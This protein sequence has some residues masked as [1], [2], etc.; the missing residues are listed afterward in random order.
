MPSRVRAL[1]AL[2]LAAR[3]GGEPSRERTC[4]MANAGEEAI[5]DCGGGLITS[6]EF[7]SFGDPAGSCNAAG[8]AAGFEMRPTCHAVGTTDALEDR[9]LGQSTCMFNVEPAMFSVAAGWKCNPPPAGGRLRLAAVLTCR[10]PGAVDPQ[11]LADLKAQAAAAH[12]SYGWRIVG[13]ILGAF[14]LYFGCGVAFKVHREG[15]RG[16]EAVP[17]LEMWRDLPFL[18]W[19]GVI[20]TVDTLKSKGRPGYDSG[21]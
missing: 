14:C 9:C 21:L 8:G 4:A 15:A 19:D 11:V 12:A 16:V 1:A 20:F 5:F 6:V 18:V 17:H 13:F 7:A 3:A 10:D 2:L